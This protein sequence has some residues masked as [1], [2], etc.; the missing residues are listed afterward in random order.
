MPGT[1]RNPKEENQERN[2]YKI[3]QNCV[4]FRTFIWQRVMNTEKEELE[5][6]SSC[7]DEIF[8]NS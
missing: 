5:Q 8:K 2:K 6:N 3:L 7:R 4:S 1:C